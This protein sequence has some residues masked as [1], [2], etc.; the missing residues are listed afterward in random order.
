MAEALL[1]ALSQSGVEALS[2][3]TAPTG[4][5][6]P[7]VRA[8]LLE[9]FGISDDR[10][11]SKSIDEFA[12]ASFDAVIT[13]CDAAAAACPSWPGARASLHW[14]LP[15]PAAI[16]DADA[17][18]RAFADVANALHRRIRDWLAEANGRAERSEDDADAG[19]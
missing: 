13:V 17:R 15:D 18:R 7:L 8:T 1:R 10:L 2:A 4:V 5:V 6:H 19:A 3:G 16:R 9:Q 12:G 11:R 14:S